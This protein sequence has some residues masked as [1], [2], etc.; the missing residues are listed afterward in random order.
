MVAQLYSRNVSISYRFGFPKVSAILRMLDVIN[1][2]LSVDVDILKPDTGAL[3]IERPPHSSS[4]GTSSSEPHGSSGALTPDQTGG[5]YA[6]PVSEG[7]EDEEMDLTPG[8]SP[9]ES[10]PR[11]FSDVDFP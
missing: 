9:I 10:L 8:S 5:Q 6:E 11:R 1:N 3:Q 4:R 7:E 2:T